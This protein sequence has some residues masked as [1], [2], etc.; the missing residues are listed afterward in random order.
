MP[1]I[2]ILRQQP[3]SIHQLSS[4]ETYNALYENMGLI[5]N[6]PDSCSSSSREAISSV[7]SSDLFSA[8]SSILS[9]HL[10]VLY[11]WMLQNFFELQP[12]NE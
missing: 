1:T 5:M 7:A 4:P 2:Q 12:K 11:N 3:K 9:I 6:M 10:F 8:S